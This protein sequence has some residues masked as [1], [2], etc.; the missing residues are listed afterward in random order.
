MAL[1]SEAA[2]V[3][4]EASTYVEAGTDLLSGDER[5][6]ALGIR[7]GSGETQIPFGNDKQM[8]WM[9]GSVGLEDKKANADS[10]RE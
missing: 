2:F 8:G 9:T 3:G 1:F 6:E 10:L 7:G 4:G 5:R